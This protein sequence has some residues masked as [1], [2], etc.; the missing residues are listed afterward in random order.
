[1]QVW[2]SN[3]SDKL[4]KQGIY[5][6]LHGSAPDHEYKIS[7]GN[8]LLLIKAVK[9][10]SL[11]KYF[12]KY[13]LDQCAD[14]LLY[15]AEL[16]QTLTADDASYLKQ[17]AISQGMTTHVIAYVRDVYDIAYSSY[18]QLVKRRTCTRT[19]RDFAL[20]DY[21]LRQFSVVPIYAEWFDEISV[22]HYDSLERSDIAT[23]ICHVI[24]VDP[25]AL[26]A[27]SGNKV[28]RSLSIY[29]SELMR[30]ANRLFMETHD[31]PST[32]FSS[33]ISDQLIAMNPELKTEIL[34]DQ[35]VLE[36]FESGM[37]KSV[38]MINEQYLQEP[39]MRIFRDT[40]KRLVT[41]VPVVHPHVEQFVRTLLVKWLEN[42]EIQP[43]LNWKEIFNPVTYSRLSAYLQR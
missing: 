3:A 20:S 33:S 12:R 26:P 42:D 32:Q 43:R 14:P 1:M 10:R 13:S 38:D 17:F 11:P 22:F 4:K 27:V 9:T 21:K 35:E 28:N 39:T 7:T 8:A 15:S 25:K 41:E 40:D 30:V 37:Q 6:P 31:K 18:L 29:E 2:L 19:F 34:L 23:P 24:G 5:Y 36:H 16:L